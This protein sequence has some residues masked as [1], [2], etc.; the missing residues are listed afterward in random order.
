MPE[1]P[2]RR[3]LH[4]DMDC[5]YA[6]VHMRD[7]PT[8]AGCP[9]VVGGDPKGRGVVAAASYEARQFGIHSAMPAAQAVRL[10]PDAV[11]LNPDFPRYRRESAAIFAIYREV[12]PLV[13][14]LSLDEAYLDVSRHLGAF[15]SATALAKEIR[16][17]VREERRLTVSVGVAPNKL[18]AKIASDFRKPDGLTVVR[19]GE[20]ESFL[21]PLPVRRLHG[22]GPSS[23]QALLELGVHT[24]AELRALS[25]D[26]LLA[27]FGHWGRTLWHYCR[28]LDDR[29]VRPHEPRR[30]LS[31]E[32]TFRTDLATL[33]EIDEV[34]AALAE[35]VANGLVR[36]DLAGC[37]ITV[38]VRYGDFTTLTRSRTL[39][40]PTASA[41]RDRRG[42]AGTGAAHR[43]RPL[44]RSACSA[45]APQTWS[46]RPSSRFPSSMR[47][48]KRNTETLRRRAPTHT[49]LMTR[50][51]GSRAAGGAG[52][53]LGR[54]DGSCGSVPLPGQKSIRFDDI[55]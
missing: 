1:P 26:R 16:H 4:C 3:I 15:P 6:A 53:V 36:R 44:S 28:G 29:P 30:S 40:V 51:P 14:P 7:D 55:P 21:A 20:V 19:P 42:G 25:L 41:R 48:W 39:A 2:L 13:Q 24:V 12:T 23:E 33:A 43:G 31:A 18:V 8:L 46:R 27:R 22:V 38:K 17:R 10:C 37:T 34:I 49:G 45:S 5:F 50:S 47:R 52:H 9:V 35:E 32:R 11:F 54:E